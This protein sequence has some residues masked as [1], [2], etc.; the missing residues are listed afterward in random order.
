MKTPG[1]NESNNFG[2]E[3][4]KNEELQEI[5]YIELSE[6]ELDFV[7]GGVAPII[8]PPKPPI[9]PPPNP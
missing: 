8:K 3:E 2:Q 7:S 6:E 5:E 9:P 4:K 1:K